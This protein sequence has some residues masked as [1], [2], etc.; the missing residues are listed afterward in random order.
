MRKFQIPSFLIFLLVLLTNSSSSLQ[1]D[2]EP[3]AGIPPDSSTKVISGANQFFDAGCTVIYGTD[4]DFAFG[5]NNEDYSNPDTRIWFIPSENGRYGRALVGYEGFFWQGGMNDQGLFFDV[6]AVDN[7][8][9][10]DQGIKSRYEGS[11]PAKALAECAKVDCVLDL[12][13]EYHAFDTWTFQFM[14]GD[15]FGNSVIIEPEENSFGGSYLVGTNFYQSMTN[16]NS[17]RYCFR[18]WTARN[19]FEA[20]DGLSLELIRDVL[21]ETHLEDVRPTQYSTIYDLKEKDIYLYFFYNFE[22]V[23][24]FDLEEELAKGYHVYDMELLFPDSTEY[25]LFS[26]QEWAR[27]SDAREAYEPV[28]LDPAIFDPYLGAFQGPENL[29]MVFPYYSIAE[30]YGDLVLM[31]MP[32]KAW[33]KLEPVS[34][35]DFFHISFYD[36]FEISFIEEDSGEINEFIFLKDGDEYLFTRIDLET[37]ED[38]QME[39]DSKGSIFLDQILKFTSTFTFKFLALILG[40]LALQLLFHYLKSLLA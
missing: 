34:A 13:Q 33:M 24:V 17:C 23:R 27:Q 11:L 6:M 38:D 31:M 18:Y 4:D 25:L 22:Q 3:A 20:A 7:P 8:I 21:N 28:D 36:H 29:E 1:V 40:L 5:G 16:L 2:Q 9:E 15:A 32:D 39:T 26:R 30:K 12:F 35:T 37:S 14:F 19:L 10:V